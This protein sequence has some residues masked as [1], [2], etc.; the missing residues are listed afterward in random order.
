M[1]ADYP[2][3]KD[4]KV[5]ASAVKEYSDVLKRLQRFSSWHKVKVAVAL[6][7]RYKRKLRGKVLAK[8][9]APSDGA[10]E[11]RPIN[12]TSI[13]PGLDVADLEE[14]EV[15]ILKQVQSDAFLSEIRSL[16]IIQAKVRNGSRELNKQKKALF[17]KA[18]SLRSVDPVLDSDGIMR[19]GRRI[20]RVNLS[21]TLKNPI[22]LP[23]SSHI[24]S[25][26]I[27]HVHERT[28]HGGR[29]MTLNIVPSTNYALNELRASG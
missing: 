13:S 11:E 26:I 24:I 10:S 27:G 29:G 19:V 28:H 9:K 17:R 20:R 23:K 7:L 14:A 4:F 25:L 22:I 21:V 15:E 12:G 18:S 6:C 8:K 3:V 2:E 16:Q 5:N 1:D